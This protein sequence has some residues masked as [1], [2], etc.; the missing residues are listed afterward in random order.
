[1]VVVDR[2]I[3]GVGVGLAAAVAVDRNR[4]VVDEFIQPP[5]VIVG[6][7]F[8]GGLAFGL[9][10]HNETIPMTALATWL[11]TARR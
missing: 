2:F 11:L 7:G 1:M 10:T 5:L 4:N 9:G 6:H 3:D 8:P